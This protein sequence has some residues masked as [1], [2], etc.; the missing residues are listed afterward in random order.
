VGVVF[1]SY[2]Y[3]IKVTL[4]VTRPAAAEDEEV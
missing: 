3:W 4:V 1:D 2:N